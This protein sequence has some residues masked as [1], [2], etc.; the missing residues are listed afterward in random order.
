MSHNQTFNP[1]YNPCL[2]MTGI[3]MLAILL[4][5]NFSCQSQ[6]FGWVKEVGAKRAPVGT[7]TY[8]VA[9][10]GAVADGETLNT[11]FIQKAIDA[12]A[13]H[14]G[15]IVTFSPGDY[16]TGSIYVK[17]GVH[18][19]IPEG[20]TILGSQ[21]IKDYPEID[22]RVAG[23]EMVWPS[24]LI[25]VL[26]Q[27]NVMISG[28]GLVNGQGKVFWDQ[29]W[30]MR[31]DYEARGLRWVVDYDC[32]R[33]RTLLVSR[34]SDVTL[35]GLN[36]Q[37]A[38]FWTIQLL[39]SK[40]CTV[41]GVTV[42]NNI[43]GHGPS[44]DGIDIDSSS[45][46]LI[47]NCDIDCNDDTYCLKAGRDADGLRVNK[48]T[49]YVVLR[50]NISRK[51]AALFTCGSE[52]SGGIRYI[53]AENMK[54]MGT[55]NGFLLKSA[56]TRGGTVEHIY[57]RNVEMK[58]VRTAINA[59][60]NWNPSYSYSKLPEEYEGKELPDHWNT[61]LEKVDPEEGLP[62]FREMHL[63]NFKISGA[64][65]LIHVSGRED[66]WMKGFSLK[67]ID[68]T[69]EKAGII[70]Y[71]KDWEVKNFQYQTEDGSDIVVEHSEGVNIPEGSKK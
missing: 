59:G 20:V 68:A 57:V 18:L 11:E 45:F 19:N 8:N 43:G 47:E 24:A 56:L 17:E 6:S 14:G 26:D 21:D 10:Y 12:C 53:L 42:R 25:N 55:S 22:T 52:T 63:E 4:G 27:E 60:V 23:I 39:Y 54:A 64:E 67:N 7:K 38:G 36:F 65:I 66:S 32:K 62:H 41:D 16:L 61:L 30:T 70:S 37:Q 1:N 15:G 34:S 2:V 71:G 28:N 44:T 35:K 5:T 46:I 33:P 3:F 50:N 51:G 13:A 58:D 29:Y 31:K 49:E 69:A 48:P 40:N 9:D